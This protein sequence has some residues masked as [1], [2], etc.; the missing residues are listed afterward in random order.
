M[1]HISLGKNANNALL[2]NVIILSI[3]EKHYLILKKI[4]DKQHI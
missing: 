1:S 2:K 4:I 3:L